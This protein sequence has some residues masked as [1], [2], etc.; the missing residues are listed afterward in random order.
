MIVIGL[1][2]AD[3]G[4]ADRAVIGRVHGFLRFGLFADHAAE[5]AVCEDIGL[6]NAGF[7]SLRFFFQTEAGF[8]FLSRQIFGMD[9]LVDLGRATLGTFHLAI[10]GGGEPLMVIEGVA[11]YG[12]S[13]AAGAENDLRFVAAFE[14]TTGAGGILTEIVPLVTGDFA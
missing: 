13:V 8:F 1:E 12:A 5:T 11:A 9:V 14:A 6:Q 10:G 7:F 2:L 3:A 4:G